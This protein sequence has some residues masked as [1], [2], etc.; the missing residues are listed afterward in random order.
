MAKMPP[1]HRRQIAKENRKQLAVRSVLASEVDEQR[2]NPT[3]P[4]DITFTMRGA[5]TVETYPC[6]KVAAQAAGVTKM[7]LSRAIFYQTRCKGRYWE[8]IHH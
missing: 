5:K 4:P 8:Y 7:A 1:Q 6:L 2:K 3:F